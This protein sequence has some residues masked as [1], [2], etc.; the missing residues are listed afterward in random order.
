MNSQQYVDSK[1]S[2]L[3][4]IIPISLD[5]PPARS[6]RRQESGKEVSLYQ[7]I[8]N[9]FFGC[10]SGSDYSEGGVDYHCLR[11]KSDGPIRGSGN[12]VDYEMVNCS[13]N[14][15]LMDGTIQSHPPALWLV[16]NKPKSGEMLGDSSAL[17]GTMR[18][19]AT[20][21][22]SS[23]TTAGDPPVTDWVE[24]AMHLS[25][26]QRLLMQNRIY[27]SSLKGSKDGLNQDSTIAAVLDGSIKLLGVFDGHGPEGDEVSSA[28]CDV[29]PKLLLKGVST[30]QGSPD[31]TREMWKDAASSAFTGTQTYLEIVT[32]QWMR[33]QPQAPSFD[34]R[35]SGTTG[36]V[37]LL[38]PPDMLLVGHVGDSKALLGHRKR[39]FDHWR[40]EEL[41]QDHK[42]SLEEERVRI[43]QAG[44]ELTAPNSDDF[45][46]LRVFNPGQTWPAINM[47]RSLGDLHAHSQGVSQNPD[48]KTMLLPIEEDMILLICS[49]GVWDV[50]DPDEAIRCVAENQYAANP[51]EILATKAKSA[52]E[53]KQLRNH[54]GY[55]DDIS[56][57]LIYL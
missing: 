57:V 38:Q 25:E 35:Q 17:V 6:R 45:G 31:V 50:V 54:P 42:G 55:C 43:Q 33:G 9:Y 19:R 30:N 14:P 5:D 26:V 18:T 28:T 48:V 15:A 44:A 7:E 29:L 51:A 13:T 8:L 21:P 52:W 24:E 10:C 41:T 2:H 53:R 49:D 37:V 12:Y 56:V 46:G 22:S 23:P 47:T 34:A 3:P 39:G 11:E 40:A 36:T 32:E 1:Q 4:P 27:V 16:R 20:V